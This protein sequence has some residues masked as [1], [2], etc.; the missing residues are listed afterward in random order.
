MKLKGIN[1]FEQHVEKVLVGAMGVVCLG[2][3]SMQFL[4]QPNVLKLSGEPKPVTP[5]RAFD[6]AERQARALESKLTTVSPKLP[7]A[8]PIDLL[9]RFEASVKGEVAPQTR[10][11]G[12]WPGVQI[13]TGA[14]T[15]R[16]DG[17]RIAAVRVPG[18]SKPD[19]V[20]ILTT[21]DPF[22]AA[23][24]P[25]L[26]A[27]L[28]KAQ[29]FDTPAV[30]LECTFDPKSLVAALEAD[31]DGS[32][33]AR[34]MSPAWW[35]G[36]VEL[37][38]VRVEREEMTSSGGWT[39]LT[40][41]PPLPGRVN[42]LENLQEQAVRMRDMELVVQDASRFASEIR[43][44]AFYRTI[45]GPEWLTPADA[46]AQEGKDEIRKEIDKQLRKRES[47]L[48]AIGKLDGA[49]GGGPPPRQPGS[50]GGGKG[51]AGGEG[52]QPGNTGDAN[53]QA[54]QRRRD[55][56]MRE[57]EE[58]DGQLR[59]LGYDPQN[60]GEGQRPAMTE[61][62]VTPPLLE[63]TAVRLWAHDLT[64]TPGKTYRYRVRVVINNPAFG[65]GP[66][67][68]AESRPLADQHTTLGEPS[69]WSDPVEVDALQA[70][71]V[72][73]ASEGGEGLLAGTRASAE[74]YA[75]YYGFWRKG[76]V[77]LEPGDSIRATARLPEKLFLIDVNAAGAAP[78]GGEA[79]PPPPS[80]PRGREGLPPP[81]GAQPGPE[82]PRPA[83]LTPVRAELPIA[84]DVVLLDVARQPSGG[85]PAGLAG[86]P[87]VRYESLFRAASGDIEVRQSETDR[88]SAKYQRVSD[89]ARQGES[90]GE[91]E[92]KPNE[93]VPPPGEGPAPRPGKAPTPPKDP[94]G[95]GGGGGGG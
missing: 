51:G 1:P 28:P 74:V 47:T 70:F 46:R 30:T 11:A 73:S 81:P 20:S 43:R 57:L 23:A 45:A 35:R 69:A 52:R 19:A 60:P 94:G 72:T 15:D 18:P 16:T 59:Q 62:Q 38:A 13:Q 22:E 54:I 36:Q 84:M 44:P 24:I 66:A 17:L 21:I 83:W 50:T 14:T 29:P 10:L 2:L 3:V 76:T 64:A 77:S 79:P 9:Q 63:D 27:M 86:S 31:P 40:E 49:G 92:V 7:D 33:P 75:F 34:A 89:S 26:A 78:P 82:G 71:F 80:G 32:G 37:L 42:L 8:K 88:S 85:A 55:R 61:P 5:G 48:E 6:T 25:A 95:G 4:Y 90:Q 68:D 91:P 56:L 12:T 65:R 93:G 87:S 39:N 67:L 53:Q 58:I 41:L